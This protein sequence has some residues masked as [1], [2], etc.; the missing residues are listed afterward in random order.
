VP[1]RIRDVGDL[2]APLLEK[3]HRFDLAQFV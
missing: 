3:R 2:W 1:E